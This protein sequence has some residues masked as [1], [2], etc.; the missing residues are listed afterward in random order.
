MPSL[1]TEHALKRAARLP[2]CYLCGHPFREN[3]QT[4]RDHVPPSAIFAQRDQA[5]PL[6][7]RTHAACNQANS[8]SDE[9]IGQLV[10]VMHGKYPDVDRLRLDLSFHT[11]PGSAVP[12]GAVAGLPFGRIVFRWLRAFHAAL[13]RDFL[14]SCGGY[15]H[16]PFPEGNSAAAF[17]PI[18]PIHYEYVRTIKKNRVAGN[19]D[20]ITCRNHQC[21][22]VC[23]WARADNRSKCAQTA[24]TTPF[25]ASTTTGSCEMVQ[26]S[27]SV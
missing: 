27:I 20:A 6:I 16:S 12:V 3:D 14:P 17:K 2:F 11:V 22:Y 9:Q 8:A 18:P 1:L 23:V 25:S 26:P 5:P 19:L 7:L 21:R 13:Y 4:N 24:A 10:A 15:I